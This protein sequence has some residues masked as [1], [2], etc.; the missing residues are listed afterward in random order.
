MCSSAS[1]INGAKRIHE[2][3]LDI[4]SRQGCANINKKTRLSRNCASSRSWNGFGIEGFIS[5]SGCAAIF[6]YRDAFCY[7]DLLFF[8]GGVMAFFL[9]FYLFLVS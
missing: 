8:F 1:D 4:L 2:Q 5:S 7:R 6:N 9:L 3:L